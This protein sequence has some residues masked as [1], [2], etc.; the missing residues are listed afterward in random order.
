MP[1]LMTWDKE[2]EAT[3]GK[4]GRGRWTSRQWGTKQGRQA[5]SLL[6]AWKQVAAGAGR[7]NRVFASPGR[8]GGAQEGHR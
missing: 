7:Q 3:L 4:A 6:W 8:D 1:D 2:T 5:L